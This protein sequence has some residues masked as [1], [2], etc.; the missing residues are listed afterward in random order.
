MFEQEVPKSMT[1][2]SKWLSMKMATMEAGQHGVNEDN[3]DNGHDRGKK[4]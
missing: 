4:M 1:V 3:P 2:Q